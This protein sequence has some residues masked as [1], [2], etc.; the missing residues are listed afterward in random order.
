MSTALTK[1]LV[2][3]HS[4][5]NGHHAGVDPEQHDGSDIEGHGGELLY[6]CRDSKQTAHKKSVKSRT[7][8][9]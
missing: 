3:H 1:G 2:V 4:L 9:R 8:H 5:S 6:H 7:K